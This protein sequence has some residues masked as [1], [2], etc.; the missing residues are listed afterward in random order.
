MS[1]TSSSTGDRGSRRLR[2]PATRHRWAATA[3][4]GR[5]ASRLTSGRD[6]FAELD[7][8]HRHVFVER[9]GVG[10]D[11]AL[12]RVVRGDLRLGQNDVE[13]V[14]RGVECLTH[15][16]VRLDQSF[17]SR[18]QLF[19]LLTQGLTPAHQVAQHPLAYPLGLGDHLASALASLLGVGVGID[20]RLLQHLVGLPADPRRCFLRL[21]RLAFEHGLGFLAHAVRLL[22]RVAQQARHVLLGLGAD[23]RRC[24]V[25]G[26][27]HLRGLLT[28]HRRQSLR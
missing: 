28:Q 9:R 12:Q 4:A 22:L 6:G 7:R 24:G 27:D 3:A 13:F 18:V 26:V 16:R 15:D 19:D 17:A 2:P 14:R 21:G 8:Q 25:R 23:V 1:S 10:V 20:A 11:G 5:F